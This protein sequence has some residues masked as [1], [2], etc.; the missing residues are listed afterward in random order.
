MISL[1][2]ISGVVTAFLLIHRETLGTGLIS[3]LVTG[4]LWTLTGGV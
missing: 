2:L 3:A 4:A 1:C